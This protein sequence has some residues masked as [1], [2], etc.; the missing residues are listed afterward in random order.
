MSNDLQLE[1]VKLGEE[2]ELLRVQLDA[3]RK[4]AEA[5]RKRAAAIEVRPPSILGSGREQSLTQPAVAV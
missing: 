1:C 4:E 5:Q 3:A 2:V